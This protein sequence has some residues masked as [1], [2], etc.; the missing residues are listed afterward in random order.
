M[1]PAEQSP[2]EGKETPAATPPQHKRIFVGLRIAPEIARELAQLVQDL[3]RTAVRPVSTADIHLTLVPPWNEACVADAIDKLRVVAGEAKAFAL[4]FQHVGY[5][6]DPKWPRLLW[7]DCAA[8]DELAELRTA[9]L[10]AYGQTDERPFRPH[11]TLAR[12]R[13]Q[14][15]GFARRHPVD[16]QLSLAQQVDAVELFQSPPPG[17]NGY[18]VLASFRLG[19]SPAS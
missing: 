4:T 13:G 5:G 18:Q 11:V 3:D 1:T 15:R 8:G 16:L 12:L 14:G 17:A 7:A 9:L 2:N 10:Q 6:P 19:E